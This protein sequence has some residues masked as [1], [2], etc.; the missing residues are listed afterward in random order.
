[1]ITRIERFKREKFLTIRGRDV[2]NEER[3]IRLTWDEAFRLLSILSA[4]LFGKLVTWSWDD[5]DQ[6]H[7]TEADLD[8]RSR[9]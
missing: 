6:K 7:E 9:V 2:H 4:M 3:I 1:M 5:G 8:K